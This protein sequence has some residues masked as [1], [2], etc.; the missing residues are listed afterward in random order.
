MKRRLTVYARCKLSK[1]IVDMIQAG[2]DPTEPIVFA[3]GR[4]YKGAHA[5]LGDKRT[6]VC[7]AVLDVLKRNFKFMVVLPDEYLTSQMCHSCHNK[8]I[9]GKDESH[10][11]YCTHC[12]YVVDRDIKATINI[13][14]VFLFHVR[15]WGRPDYLCRPGQH[16]VQV[17]IAMEPQTAEV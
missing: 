9:P 5:R 7:K 6:P 4:N 12:E 1:M 2:T 14:Q 10:E 16:P 3:L 8:L 11:K 13:L 17:A 15:G